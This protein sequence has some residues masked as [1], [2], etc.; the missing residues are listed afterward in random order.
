MN[1]AL[2]FTT[3]PANTILSNLISIVLIICALAAIYFVVDLRWENMGVDFP[4]F[5]EA[6]LSLLRGESPYVAKGFFNPPWMAIIFIPFAILPEKIGLTLLIVVSYAALFYTAKKMGLDML[7]SAILA[8]SPPVFQTITNGNIDLLL[9]PAFALPPQIGMFFLII[10]PQMG[11]AFIAYWGIVYLIEKDWKSLGKMAGIGLAV[12]ALS[13]AIW[14]FWPAEMLGAD[15]PV[16]APWNVSMFPAGFAF[17]LVALAYAVKERK[18]EF[19]MGASPF[20]APY[21][22]LQSFI[23]TLFPAAK[24]NRLYL[25]LMV[26]GW[27]FIFILRN[28]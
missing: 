19:A 13:F 2:E 8:I 11:I 7:T 24:V 17:G 9:L 21:S 20:F 1:K 22:T 5:R 26:V 6:S 12:C 15:A 18:P 28:V 14:G 23:V 3:N 10:K 27:Y 25:I 16:N 4:I